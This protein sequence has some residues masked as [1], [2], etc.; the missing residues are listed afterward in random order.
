MIDDFKMRV[1]SV[2]DWRTAALESLK[3]DD[4]N[5]LLCLQ[6]GKHTGT[7]CSKAMDSGIEDCRWH[8]IVIDAVLPA[9]SSIKIS[10][11][12]SNASDQQEDWSSPVIFRENY[13]DALVQ[14]LPGQYIRLKIE[15]S[16][17][18]ESNPALRLIKLYYPRL[19]YL[20]YLPTVYQK[21]SLNRE[22]LERFLSVFES[23]MCDIEEII[24]HISMYFDPLVTHK[25]FL[26]W[27]AEWL[28]LKL[29]ESL[30]DKK[31][32]FITRAWEFYVSKG[33]L[34]GLQELA[35]FLTGKRCC[36]KEYANNIFRTYGME[37]D[38]WGE[39]ETSNDI[40]CRQFYRTTSKTVNTAGGSI[41]KIRDNAGTYED[42]LHYVYGM[43]TKKERK[44]ARNVII[45][46]IFEGKG[47]EG[48]LIRPHELYEIAKSFVP[49]FVELI[50][51]RVE[52]D[53]EIVDIAMIQ[54]EL[55]SHIEIA[56]DETCDAVQVTR[57]DTIPECQIFTS[58]DVAIKSITNK[59][60]YCTFH[61]GI[62]AWLD[63]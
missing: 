61:D 15:F 46:F 13:R 56:T 29:Y 37:H 57:L 35:S 31:R 50:I 27:L 48:S 1:L 12:T 2:E 3:L 30:G 19:S 17:D 62:N 5:N 9:R 10:F 26:P 28:S 4:S 23:R 44:Y 25:D 39:T 38:E 22:F 32:E 11:S 53:Q 20:R 36:V 14:A 16:G 60:K 7:C 54:E 40:P 49:V 33:T 34:K 21:D 63:S 6:K 55:R 43:D 45:L 42:E 8:R 41:E 18:G 24:N 51:K 59:W 52:E 58:Y 47:E